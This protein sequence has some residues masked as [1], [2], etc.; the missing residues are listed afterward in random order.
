MAGEKKG[1]RRRGRSRRC[2][3]AGVILLTVYPGSYLAMSR[4]AFRKAD[5]AN[6]EGFCFFEPR[7][8]GVKTADDWC[9]AVYWPMVEI[10]KA[11]GTGR[12]RGSDP[13]L[14]LD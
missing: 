3:I 10:D 9:F 4:I 7:T 13:I 14:H 1:E 2:A 11:L 8:R 12:P 6:A 5:R